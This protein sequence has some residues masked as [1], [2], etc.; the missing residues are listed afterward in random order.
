MQSM[1][2]L[3]RIACGFILA[4][5]L[6]CQG[7]G[8]YA[9]YGMSPGYYAAPNGTLGP[10][11][12]TFVPPAG[13]TGP[14]SQLGPGATIAPGGA[15]QWSGSGAAGDSGSTNSTY[16]PPN[17]GA[18]KPVPTYSDES[19]DE[20]SASSDNRFDTGGDFGSDGGFGRGLSNPASAGTPARD[21]AD[22][23]PNSTR[24]RAIDNR[25]FDSEATPFESNPQ[26]AADAEAVEPFSSRSSSGVE[27]EFEEPDAES[28]QEPFR[29][30]SNT[31]STS[32]PT[33]RPNPYDYDRENY[34]WLRGVVDY[35]TKH[36]TWHII[37]NLRPDQNDRYGGSSTLS[38]SPQ[39][40]SLKPNDI[41]LVEGRF[42][43]NSRDNIGKPT[44]Q[45]DHVARLVPKAN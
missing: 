39:L 19:L 11:G 16:E 13:A 32:I 36:Q 35:D 25:S 42:D 45:I 37:Y 40:N 20:P 12:P 28:F 10:Q 18:N 5:T 7:Y 43:P 33:S 31:V 3:S 22:T 26:P 15:G 21:A 30:A 6:G 14:N 4:S 1:H 34:T 17:E 38:A 29:P 8:P 41:V 24:P 9:P 27:L 23:N 2:C 44:Y